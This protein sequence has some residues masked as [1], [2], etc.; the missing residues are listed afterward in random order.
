M[1][2]QEL[3]R[4]LRSRGVDMRNDNGKL[5]LSAPRGVID[6]ALQAQLRDRRDELLAALAAD[7]ADADAAFL[8]G[9]THPLSG[10]QQSIL[11]LESEQPELGV[12]NLY[13]CERLQGALGYT[14][15]EHAVQV[16]L[17]RHELLRAVIDEH[18]GQPVQKLQPPHAVELPVENIPG[19]NERVLAKRL[20]QELVRPFDP[21]RGPLYR[22]RLFRLARDIH[23]LL[24]AVDH[25]IADGASMAI[26]RRELFELYA[27]HRERRAPRLPVLDAR[28]VELVREERRWLLGSAAQRQLDYWKQRLAGELPQLELPVDHARPAMPSGQGGVFTLHLGKERVTALSAAAHAAGAS[29]FM[30][31][32]AVVA[33]LLARLSGQDEIVLGMPMEN[34]TRKGSEN[35]VGLFINPVALRLDVDRKATFDILLQQVRDRC[36]EALDNQSI[37]FDKVVE[38][39][40]PQRDSSRTPVFQALV[41]YVPDD[42]CSRNS[43]GLARTPLDIRS[44][45]AQADIS[46]WCRETD[47][48]LRIDLEYTTDLFAARTAQHM[49][50]RFDVLLAALVRQPAAQIG[51]VPMLSPEEHDLLVGAW[52]SGPV[53]DWPSVTVDEML[54]AQC[55]R[56]GS[57]TASSSG[58]RRLSYTA[59][60]EYANHAGRILAE[61][62]VGRGDVVGVLLERDERLP[63]VLLAV[64]ERGAAYLPLDPEAPAERLRWMLDDAG[65]VLVIASDARDTQDALSAYN[66]RVIDLAMLLSVTTPTAYDNSRAPEH[67]VP[68]EPGDVAYVIYTSGSTGR[69]KGVMVPHHAV[70]NF[71]RSMQETLQVSERDRF[72]AVTTLTFD[73]A[74]LE[75]L[76]PLYLGACT[77]IV[78]R[79]TARDGDALQQ[80][81]AAFRPTVMQATPATWQLLLSAGWQGDAG[82]MALS[83]G[84][85]L[86]APLARALLERSRGVFNLYGPTETTVWSTAHRVT[87]DDDPVSIGRPIANTQ[88]YVLDASGQLTPPGVPGE[89]YIGGDGVTLG[90]LNRPDLNAERFVPDPFGTR[91]DSK[92]YRTGD[93]VRFRDDGRLEC[94][95]RVDFQIKLRGHRIEPGEI[96]HALEAH[97]AVERA[98]VTVHG[99]DNGRDPRLVAYMTLADGARVGIDAL[100]NHLRQRLPAYM[101]PQHY[102]DL[103]V[104]PLTPS[105]KI[106]RKALPSPLVTPHREYIPPGTNAE[107]RVAA[108]WQETLGVDTVSANDNFFDLGGHSLSSMKVIAR[109]GEELGVRLRPRLLVLNTLREIAAACDEMA[110]RSEEHQSLPQAGRW[111]SVVDALFG[112][113]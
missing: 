86:P 68:H 113:A 107:R 83:G 97:A 34:R 106:D 26:L 87:R 41:T 18:A 60:G 39:I 75:L 33:M 42:N 58:E 72:L 1:T 88:V 47:T 23:V 38:A 5:S 77:E 31:V 51:Q 62:G 89:L 65:A 112:R 44:G 53:R 70:M 85:A 2:I 8:P 99:F 32:S 27:A 50:R 98:V 40:A 105:G 61:N 63:A 9:G 93:R 59:L 69:P 71:L 16:L 4:Q 25:A 24:F 30:F 95:G 56:R 46:F 54:R 3:V 17:E 92:L 36:M 100:R 29:P 96:E 91:G 7:A 104:L 43:A 64:L 94:L 90:Y 22:F 74:V 6:A 80:R 37:P 111:K 109:I 11:Y 52:G 19:G 110:A 81:L 79:D 35:V 76:L 10:I 108:L 66:G 103:D 55:A 102:M 28:Y 101:L 82:L 49:L 15:L 48:G 84:E 73:I 20:Q 67:R 45:T 78:P 21:Y 57:E 13:L 14:A 12:Y